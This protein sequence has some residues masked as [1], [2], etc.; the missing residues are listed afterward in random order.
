[1]NSRLEAE[2]Q[3]YKSVFI[4]R[5]EEWSSGT[6]VNIHSQ[7]RGVEFRDISQYSFSDTRSG[8]QDTSQYSF[9][10][11]RSGV[12]DT[13]Q[14]SFSDTSSGVQGHKSVFILRH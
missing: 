10:D 4:L 5:H 11:M 7:T 13:S 3:G 9:S 1:M 6:Q 12:Q 8:V 14:Y 2:V